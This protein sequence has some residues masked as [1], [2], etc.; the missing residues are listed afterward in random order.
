MTGILYRLHV[1]LSYLF[2]LLLRSHCLIGSARRGG[3]VRLTRS[4]LR[5]SS[6]MLVA[7]PA[8]PVLF[9]R[10]LCL[11][12]CNQRRWLL[13][14]GVITIALSMAQ[15]RASLPHRLVASSSSANSLQMWVNSLTRCGSLSN[16]DRN[17]LT[18]FTTVPFIYNRRS[19]EL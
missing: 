15:A 14:L 3:L 10:R 11:F 6:F 2:Q 9:T 4:R 17:G 7:M 18:N 1:N 5:R 13:M 12:G 16:F 19:I 8:H